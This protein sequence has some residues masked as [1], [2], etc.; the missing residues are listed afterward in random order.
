MCS[1]T[2]LHAKCRLSDN[3]HTY[4]ST[5]QWIYLSFGATIW[6]TLQGTSAAK[7]GTRNWNW[8]PLVQQQEL[9]VL[10]IITDDSK[11]KAANSRSSGFWPSLNSLISG[12]VTAMFLWPMT[13]VTTTV[14]SNSIRWSTMAT[15]A[16]SRNGHRCHCT[17]VF[18]KQGLLSNKQ[19]CDDRN[20]FRDFFVP[21]KRKLAIDQSNHFTYQT[22]N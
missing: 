9:Q 20:I 21:Q 10:Q 17:C 16:E 8:H 15:M 3:L 14:P 2:T 6:S 12:P 22:A 19:S 11:V 1:G 7:A 13:L 5:H 4:C 18:T